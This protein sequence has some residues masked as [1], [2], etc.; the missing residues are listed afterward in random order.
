MALTTMHALLEAA[1]RSG[2]AVGAFNVFN[3]ESAMAVVEAARQTGS[4]CILALAESHLKYTPLE[5]IGP[6]L[7]RI[8]Q[9]APVPVAVQFDH[10]KSMDN[11]R[12]ALELGFSAVMWDGYDL[13]YEEK[14]R[15]TREVVSLA[16]RYGA[17]V[18]APLG[19]IGKVGEKAA[20]KYAHDG[21]TDPGLVRDFVE[22]TGIHNLAVAIGSVHGSGRNATTL[23]FEILKAIGRFPG[24]YLSLHG[25]S[26]VS[27]D[28]YRTAI[29]LGVAKI[30][31][32]TRV[33][34][35]ATHAMAEVLKEQQPRFPDLLLHARSG[36]T[37]EVAGLMTLFNSKAAL[38]EVP[39]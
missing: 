22:R 9:D 34:M 5:Y 38:K 21:P 6:A 18:E 31:I 24:A 3:F 10:G 30:S 35:A 14:I 25:G 26:G 7:M 27:D 37:N 2:C 33:A 1:A 16:E 4:P 29:S 32:F 12:R 17:A 13:E 19:R 28:D 36:I 11:V 23:N 15:Q 39:M 20:P 8:A